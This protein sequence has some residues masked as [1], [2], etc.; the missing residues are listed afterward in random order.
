MPRLTRSHLIVI[1]AGLAM[2]SCAW[3]LAVAGSA[4]DAPADSPGILTKE[5]MLQDLARTVI[6]PSYRELSAS[7]RAMHEAATKLRDQP[8]PST[9]A[10][11]RRSWEEMAVKAALVRSINYGPVYEHGTNPLLFFFPTRPASIERVIHSAQPLNAARI[12]E[13]GAAAKGIQALEYLLFPEPGDVK[14]AQIS[15]PLEDNVLPRLT[16]DAAV[17]RREYVVLLA[18]ELATHTEIVA[19]EWTESK[20]SAADFVKGGQRSISTLVNRLTWCLEHRIHAQLTAL[21]IEPAALNGL[22]SRTTD[23]LIQA[24]FEGLYRLFRGQ[25][26]AGLESYLRAIGSS[27]PDRLTEKF[28]EVERTASE[29]SSA[30]NRE[31][32]VRTAAGTCHNLEVAIK[33]EMVSALGIALSFSSLDGD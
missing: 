27:T 5:K 6:A 12:A 22:R 16:G 31:E 21:E 7:C 15:A 26:G 29:L 24:S 3:I 4:K 2:A 32:A 19:R 1:F 18:E 23:R 13:L 11:A 33:V 14:A 20:G 28:R 17:R 8:D 30:A 9:L 10:Q 25:G